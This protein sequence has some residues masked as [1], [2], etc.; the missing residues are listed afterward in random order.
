[1]AV[2]FF[3]AIASGLVSIACSMIGLTKE[4]TF[5][6]AYGLPVAGMFIWLLW[7]LRNFSKACS[8][9]IEKGDKLIS[10]LDRIEYDTE[11]GE[12]EE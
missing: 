10:L 11:R 3:I 6:V 1:M 12:Q 2:I 4:T 8:R 9:E 7:E 5:C